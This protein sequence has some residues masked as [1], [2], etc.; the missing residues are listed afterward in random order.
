M[1]VL[2]KRKDTRRWC[3]LLAK[4]DGIYVALFSPGTGEGFSYPGRS[5]RVPDLQFSLQNQLLRALLQAINSFQQESCRCCAEL[6]T[7]LVH[8]GQR[9]SR[10]LGEVQIVKTDDRRLF[11]ACQFQLTSRQTY[12]KG[13]P[14]LA[15]ARGGWT[16]CPA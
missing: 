4:L 1:T 5:S 12:S 7:G 3:E 9:G 8:R 6:I 14:G 15:R 11:R 16:G 2:R 13:H 10:E